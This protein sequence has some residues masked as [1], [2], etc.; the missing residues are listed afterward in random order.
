MN[1][2]LFLLAMGYFQG[3]DQM[4]LVD[5]VRSEFWDLQMAGMKVWPAASMV[6]FCFVPAERRAAFGSLVNLGWNVYLGLVMG[7]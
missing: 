1:N 5:Y 6:G 3:M 2:V 7:K 4:Q